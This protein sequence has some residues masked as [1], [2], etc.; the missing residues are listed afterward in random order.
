MNVP[1]VQDV[2]HSRFIKNLTRKGKVGIEVN[3]YSI[4]VKEDIPGKGFLELTKKRTLNSNS[5]EF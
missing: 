4:I 1:V 2:L 3:G 5:G